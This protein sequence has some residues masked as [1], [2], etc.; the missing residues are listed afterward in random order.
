M[1]K[2]ASA[3]AMILLVGVGVGGC[4]SGS[5]PVSGSTTDRTG[6]A[7]G[8]SARRV[9]RGVGQSAPISKV[10]VARRT[11]PWHGRLPGLESNGASGCQERDGRR[12]QIGLFTDVPVP[13]CIRVSGHQQ[14]LIVN[15]TG[16]YRRSEGKPVVVRLGPYSARLLPQQAALFGPVGR[17]LGRGL[18]RAI[19]NGGSRGA[20]LVLPKDCAILRPEPGEAL[21]FKK[22]RPGRSRR[23]QRTE[24]RMG[25][26]ACRGSDLDISADSHSGVA[27][28]TGYSKLIITNL[29]RR[30]CTVAGVPTVVAIDRQ[31]KSLDQAEAVPHLRPGSRG[32]RFRVKLSGG[33]SANFEVAHDD[34]IGSGRCRP[35]R[36]YGLRVSVPGTG[37]TQLVPLAM[38]YC[39]PP[40]GGLGLRVGRIE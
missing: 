19:A 7:A 4:A 13:D 6:N 38:S 8:S 2:K 5:G 37:P 35:A 11:K 39:P 3:V 18:H 15:R 31:G 28:G 32:G 26:P 29:S 25:A 27:A 40:R 23:W 12:P 14:V 22:D 10:I 33:D 36:T 21:C 17:F 9:P 20:V 16:A 24:T 30:P 1:G 34:G